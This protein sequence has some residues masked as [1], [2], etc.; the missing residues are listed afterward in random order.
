[1]IT[2]LAFLLELEPNKYKSLPRKVCCYIGMLLA[3][4]TR[5]CYNGIQVFL[6]IRMKI[7]QKSN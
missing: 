4:V 5:H 1:M 7:K 6:T 3:I 2:A